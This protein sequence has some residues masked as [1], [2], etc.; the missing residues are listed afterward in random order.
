MERIASAL[1]RIAN[2]LEAPQ[3]QQ[4]EVK[5]EAAPVEYVETPEGRIPVQ[6]AS[7]G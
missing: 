3:E 4:F 2:A 7:F 6:R 1:E 5:Q